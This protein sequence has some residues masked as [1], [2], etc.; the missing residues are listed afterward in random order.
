MFD[1][2]WGGIWSL[3]G[4]GGRDGGRSTTVEGMAGGNWGIFEVDNIGER[5]GGRISRWEGDKRRTGK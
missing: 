2:D 5:E 1:S 4:E 3:D